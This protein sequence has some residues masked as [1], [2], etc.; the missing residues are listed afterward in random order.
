VL[1]N[2]YTFVL[3][4]LPLA[5]L[6]WW[7]L[8]GRR[9]R[10]LFLTLASYLFY[11]W[12]DFRF[13]PLMVLSTSADY[14]AGRMIASS[15]VTA[16]R[17]T[18]L[19]LLLLLNLGILGVFKYYDFFVGSLEGLARLLGYHPEWPFLRV[20]LPVGISFYTFNSISYTIDVYRGK[21]A[22]ARSFLEFSA[23]VAMFPHLVAGPIVRYADMA[24]QFERLSR[25]PQPATWVSGLWMF[26]IGMA[27]KVLVADVVARGVV[28][29]LWAHASGLNSGEAW[30][31]ALG[32]TVQIYFDFSG[33]SDMAVG[34]ALLL[35][36]R[37]PQNF[38]SPYQASN[39]AE[40]WRRW[41]MSLS[42]WLRD[43]LYIPLGGSRASTV[44]AGRNLL[45]T[46]FLGGLWHGAAWTFVLWG[47]Y[48]GILLASHAA[49]TRRAWV[50]RSK[51]L[52]VMATF[53]AVVVGWVFFRAR[54]LG[55]AFAV[56]GA[57][58]GLR[59]PSGGLMHLVDSPWTL[60]LTAS[61]LGLCFWAPNTWQVRF[62]RTRL[63]AAL[64]A[65][66]LVAC[67]LRFAQPA[68]FVYFQF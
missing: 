9:S 64:L 43:Y 17:T 38:D 18:V 39:I 51:A 6:G 61:A 19:V 62:P 68:P 36:F 65:A 14:V 24:S 15:R 23:F 3:V 33:Y 59:S 26:G 29:P 27:K 56:L 10:L 44:I 46:M 1:F 31:A 2:S 7:G 34:L 67:I 53:L 55:E 52:S 54:S 16:R 8:R 47:L 57:M 25:R 35:G 50:P 12:W 41:H 4:F 20:V 28:D 49:L 5:L 48:H 21:L 60:V 66:L 32:Y 45:I 37:F 40:F 58:T 11:A 13:V 42:F 63:A 30:L 22:P